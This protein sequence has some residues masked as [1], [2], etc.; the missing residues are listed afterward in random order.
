MIFV[1]IVEAV[2]LKFC[3]LWKLL[4]GMILSGT[5][6]YVVYAH[7]AEVH[8]ISAS[9]FYHESLENIA[10]WLGIAKSVRAHYM[11]IEVD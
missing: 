7:C 9:P 10:S 6:Q 2:C 5:V 3:F 1:N 8:A 11:K 4:Y